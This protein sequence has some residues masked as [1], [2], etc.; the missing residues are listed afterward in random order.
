MFE[1]AISDMI[2]NHF[3]QINENMNIEQNS[4]ALTLP[5]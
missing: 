5:E 4:F 3:D 1:H 2:Q